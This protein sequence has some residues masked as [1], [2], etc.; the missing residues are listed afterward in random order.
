MI[1]DLITWCVFGL[2]AGALA[3]FLTPG[4]DPMGCIWTMGLGIAGSLL[5]GFL[6]SV[7]FGSGLEDEGI[8]PAGFLGAV[9]GGI[10]VLLILR[11]FS[12]KV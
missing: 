4:R 8:Q 10:L 5:M 9:I 2:L 3:R 11:S 6:F 7:L 12:R 1:G